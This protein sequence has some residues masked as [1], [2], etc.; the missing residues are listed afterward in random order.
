MDLYDLFNQKIFLEKL[1]LNYKKF[2]NKQ[3]IER[4][5]VPESRNFEN[6]DRNFFKFLQKRDKKKRS[7]NLKYHKKLISFLIIAFLYYLFIIIF[8]DI[9][10]FNVHLS[11]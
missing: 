10:F 9:D 4:L 6:V 8:C 3:L 2:Y 5:K 1:K 7:S 11:A